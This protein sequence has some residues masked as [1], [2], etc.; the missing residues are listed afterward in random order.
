MKKK[1]RVLIFTGNGKGK[2]TAALGMALRASGHGLRTLILQ[3]LKSDPNTG[4]MAAFKDSPLVELVQMGRGFVPSPA[5]P[6][7]PE[8]REKAREA[9]KRAGEALRSGKYDLIVLDEICMAVA[10]GLLTEEEVLALIDETDEG[11]CLVLTGRGATDRLISRADTV[12]EM[13]C[14]K[15]GFDEGWPAQKGVEY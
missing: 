12:T 13:S 4:E 8:H 1:A 5:S 10:K 7:F 3:F 2:T 11:S 9:M 14:M 15:H 6:A